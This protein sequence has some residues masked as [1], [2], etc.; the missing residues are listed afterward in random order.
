MRE[1]D[2]NHEGGNVSESSLNDEVVQTLELR[3]Q[4]WQEKGDGRSCY[5]HTEGGNLSKT[6]SW[7]SVE[8]S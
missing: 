4:N 1:N 8:F 6:G 5:F 3:L 7:L 2:L